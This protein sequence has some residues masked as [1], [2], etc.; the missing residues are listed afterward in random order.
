MVNIIDL[1]GVRNNFGATG[2][3]DGTLPGDAF[4]FDGFV[5]IKDLNGVRN[6]FGAGAA[7]P[8]PSTFALASLFAFVGIIA[9][10]RRG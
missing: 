10:R 2:P 1:N 8:E 7:V 5:N 6:N 4:P 9:R 3:D